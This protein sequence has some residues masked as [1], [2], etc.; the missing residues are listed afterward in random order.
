MS[1]RIVNKF[2]P[3]VML[4]LVAAACKKDE[5][6]AVYNLSAA[7]FTLTSS[8]TDVVLD[9]SKNANTAITFTWPAAS[10]GFDADVTY[11]LQFGQAADSF[12]TPTSVI[13]GHNVLSKDY[14]VEEL[15]KIAYQN[16]ALPANT[17]SEVIVRI[18]ADVNQNGTSSNGSASTI[19]PVY[20]DTIYLNITPYKIL[21]IYPTLSGSERCR[22]G[23]L[24][25]HLPL[26]R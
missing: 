10:F 3:V 26:H 11:T 15:N 22:D 16:L 4:I 24:Q 21:I 1:F 17:A 13:I 5:T 23:R 7:D 18:K 20:S 8:A 14:T 9:S 12:K 19:A 2:I 6:K 25:L